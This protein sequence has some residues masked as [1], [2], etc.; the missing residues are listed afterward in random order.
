MN[1][2]LKNGFNGFIWSKWFEKKS[3]ERI[4]WYKKSKEV[5][6]IVERKSLQENVRKLL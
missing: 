3:V 5:K 4:E 6:K 2:Q 1:E